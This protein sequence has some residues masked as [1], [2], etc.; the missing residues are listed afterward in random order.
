MA[1]PNTIYAIATLPDPSSNLTDFTVLVD[2]SRFPQSWW[3]EVD[4]SDPTK[5]R[6]AK[7][8][9]TEL[10]FD[11]LSFDDVAETGWV[12]ILW[13][14]TNSS[15]STEKIRIYP[16]KAAN[17]SYGVSDTYGQYNAYDNNW[18][19][20]WPE[21]AGSDRTTNQ[22]TA[23]AQGTLTVGGASGQVGSATD[24]P[25]TDSEYAE[26]SNDAA[27]NPTAALTVFI[28][29]NL[30]SVS[31]YDALIAKS[32]GSGISEGFRMQTD[33]TTTNPRWLVSTTSG[34]ADVIDNT[35]DM[36][37]GF[38]QIVGLFDNG[39]LELFVDGSSKGTNSAGSTI[40]L[41][42]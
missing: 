3:D 30:D 2:A 41:R 23:T 4:T 33:D 39:S 37:D 21:G 28:T 9:G 10:A 32:N 25:G 16:P 20:Y 38:H 36:T 11:W 29:V 35:T 18:I 26:V 17:S 40:D 34:N 12:R 8:D 31:D 27:L 42:S 5:G 24:Y 7:D 15:V 13:S 1:L 6:A 19:G 14:G 22:L